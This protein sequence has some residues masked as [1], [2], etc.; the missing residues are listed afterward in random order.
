MTFVTVMK[1]PNSKSPVVRSSWP[2]EYD[3]PDCEH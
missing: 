2:H 3:E 1:S